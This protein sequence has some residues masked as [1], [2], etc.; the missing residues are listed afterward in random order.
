MGLSFYAVKAFLKHWLVNEERHSIQSPL[1]FEIYNGLLNYSKNA[2]DKDLDLEE[3]RH[4][5][6]KDDQVLE[7][8]DFGAGSKKLKTNTRIASDITKFSTSTRKFSQLYQYFC[9]ITPAEKVLELGT[10]VGINA[11]Y[12]S[13]EVKGDLYSFEGAEAL[14]QKAQENNPPKNIHYV[15]GQIQDTL[16]SIL[17][18]NGQVDFVLI[19][20]THTYKGTKAYFELILPYLGATSIVAIAD[21]H[22]SREMN[23]AWEEIKSHPNIS[24]SMDFYECGI[25]IFKKGIAKNHYVLHY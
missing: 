23:K 11:R 5:L 15:L 12:L 6:L 16:P 8:E 20:A 3:F 22:W 9:S 2:V 24:I 21:I 7:I 10:C 25:L 17:S 1:A 13:R 14:F 4:L 18:E 19:D